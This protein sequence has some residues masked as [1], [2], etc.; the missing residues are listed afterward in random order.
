MLV[1]VLLLISSYL[2]GSLPFG[3]WIARRISGVDIR[4]VGSGN[5]GSTNVTRIC[6]PIAGAGVMA[7]D[8]AKGIVPPL[9]GIAL[10]LDSKWLILAALI[11]ILGHNFSVFLGF[12]GGK[13]IATSA[14]ALLGI[15]FPVGVM[16]LIIFTSE[17]LT[18]RY[19]SVGSL[20]AAVS[21]PFGMRYFYPGDNYRLA[22]A[23]LACIMA[24]YKHRS[25]IVRLANGVEP[26]V[27]LRRR[28]QSGPAP[29][30]EAHEPSDGSQSH[31]GS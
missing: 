13:G 29:T 9:V 21:L 8:I 27:S 4:T 24:F 11:A 12:K 6:G 2:L 3:L 22:F 28:S 19:V 26:R 25:N 31:A 15:S 17:V 20:L 30:S 7:L 5:I 18:F 23:L 16:A 10:K 1:I 14:G